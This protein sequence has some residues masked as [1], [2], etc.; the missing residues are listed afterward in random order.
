MRS[1]L[2]FVF[3]FIIIAILGSLAI[4][5]RYETAYP[6][7]IGP[8]LDRRVRT[9]HSEGI[10]A[11]QPKIVLMGDSTL[12]LAV[13]FEQLASSLSAKT[14]GIAIPGSS[15]ALWYLIIKNNIAAANF[16]PDYL[17]IFFREL[18]LTTPEYRVD[19]NYFTTIDEFASPE[20]EQ[21]IQ[22]SYLN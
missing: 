1:F 20:D 7:S 8:K 14:Y 2:Q 13:D 10:S 16:K 11:H 15:S 21:L 19:G 3:F 17:V 9:T 22:F 6:K 18:M 5:I 4:S 12:K